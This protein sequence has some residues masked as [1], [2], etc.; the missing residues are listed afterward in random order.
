VPT[1]TALLLAAVAIALGLGVGALLRRSPRAKSGIARWL[2]WC[3][4]TL[5]TA[6]SVVFAAGVIGVVLQGTAAAVTLIVSAL[7]LIVAALLLWRGPSRHLGVGGHWL[8]GLWWLWA[9]ARAHGPVLLIMFIPVALIA[10]VA[11]GL[12]RG[13]VQTPN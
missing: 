7:A 10:L 12:E 2:R 13:G 11:A 1:L 8:G 3:A 5:G 4:A 9:G 6:V